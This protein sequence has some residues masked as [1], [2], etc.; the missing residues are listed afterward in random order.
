MKAII[1]IA[2]ASMIAMVAT[3]TPDSPYHRRIEGEKRLQAK[4]DAARAEGFAAGQKSQ[5]ATAKGKRK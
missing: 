1:A 4:L 2:C 3:A 5:C